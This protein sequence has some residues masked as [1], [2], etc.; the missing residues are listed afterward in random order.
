MDEKVHRIV[1]LVGLP[2]SGKSSLLTDYVNQGFMA[3]DDIGAQGSWHEHPVTIRHAART[4]DVI[5]SDV[6]F[7]CRTS[8]EAATAALAGLKV[9]G[10][11]GRDEFEKEVGQPI[12]WICFEN[13][14]AQCVKNCLHLATTM[15]RNLVFE[16]W[17]IG[18][19]TAVYHPPETPLPVLAID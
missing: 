5:M 1:G 3:F 11:K 17:L 13:N 19:L 8:E 18:V 9:P 7:C 15:E 10:F 6:L 14:A 2:A 16:K 4:N 12:E